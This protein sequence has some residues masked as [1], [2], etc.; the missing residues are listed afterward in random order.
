MTQIDSSETAG[1]TLANTDHL[2]EMIKWRQTRPVIH[3]PVDLQYKLNQN[4]VVYSDRH[5][6][7]VTNVI[8]VASALQ[9]KSD[10]KE[11]VNKAE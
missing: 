1:P 8:C 4:S 3:L 2:H 6:K 9:L 11:Q 5:N 7:G 10:L